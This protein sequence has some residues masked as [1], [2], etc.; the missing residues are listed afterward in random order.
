M[1]APIIG[2]AAAAAA[3][4]VAKKI[5]QRTASGITGAGARSVNPVYKQVGP[6]VKVVKPTSDAARA[7]KNAA[8]TMKVS[9]AKSGGTA[10]LH[11]AISSAGNSANKS[12]GMKTPTIKIKSK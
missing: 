1:P 8:E 3:R 11:S 4:I 5:A 10:S 6:S 12:M 9:G 2:A 7:T